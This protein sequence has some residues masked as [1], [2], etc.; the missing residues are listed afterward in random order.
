MLLGKKF[1]RIKRSFN[2][3]SFEVAFTGKDGEEI[4][5]PR[6]LNMLAVVSIYGKVNKKAV[7]KECEKFNKFRELQDKL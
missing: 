3:S 7:V 6:K 4:K 1:T 5:L 2:S